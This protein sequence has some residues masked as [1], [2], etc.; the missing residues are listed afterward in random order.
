MPYEVIRPDRETALASVVRLGRSC[1][2]RESLNWP[3]IPVEIDDLEQ[4]ADVLEGWGISARPGQLD[5]QNAL[6]R[7]AVWVRQGVAVRQL[8]GARRDR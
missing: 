4:L 5:V 7:Y 3:R 6:D 1:W 8:K 2:K